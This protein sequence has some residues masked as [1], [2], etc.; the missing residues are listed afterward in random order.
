[1]AHLI[2]AGAKNSGFVTQQ[3]ST[4]HMLQKPFPDVGI[5]RTQWII[6]Q[7]DI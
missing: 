3:L 4:N 2:V 6:K 5:N 1:M 7:V